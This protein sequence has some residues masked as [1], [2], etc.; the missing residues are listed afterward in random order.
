MEA[1]A[2][3]FH[4]PEKC[5]RFE[6]IKDTL[7][8][9]PMYLCPERALL[10]TDYFKHHDDPKEPMVIRKAKAFRH[11]LENKSVHIFPEELIV[12]NIGSR[13]KSAIIQPELA[14]VFVSQDLL[15]IDK[16][17]TTPLQSPWP[18]RIKLITKVLPY[19]LFRNMIVRAF[20]PNLYEFVRYS[21]EQ[22]NAT[23]YLVNE[24][25]G[26]GHF[27][28]NYPKMI[29]LGVNGYLASMEDK[30]GDLHIAARIACEGLLAYS[31]RLAHEAEQ[32]A[33][34][35]NDSNRAAE[36]R[37]I[38]RIC[39][40]V[41]REPAESFHEALQSLWLT[42]LG[43]CLEGINSAISFGR[44]DQYLYPY[45][46]NDLKQG[47]I[48]PEQVRELLLCFS[49]KTTEHVFLIS[50]RTSTHH[51]G[52]L[53]VQAAT[54]GGMDRDGKDAT[55]DLTYLF[56]DVMELSGL[57][58][59][60]Y[61]ARIHADSPREYINRASDVARK[62][63]GVPALFS[64]NT[65]IESLLYHGYPLEEARDYG[66][67]GC[68]EL[69]LP[70]K[71]F[72][73]T[74]AALFN[75]PVCI[76][77]ALNQGKPFKGYRR[78]G[79]PTPDPSSFTGMDQFLDAFQAQVD[80]MTARMIKDLQIIETG[81]RDYHPTPFSSM[82]V[83]GCIESGR[84]VTAGGALYNSSGIQGV[85]VA[86]TADCLAAIED[87][88]FRRKK[89]SLSQVIEAIKCNF[90]DAPMLRAE[91]VNAPK[92]GNDE[93]LPDDYAALVVK[94]FHAALARHSNT[95]GGPYVPGFYSST[96]HVAF[97]EHT[98]ALPNGRLAAM[99]FAASLGSV[100][101]MDRCGPTALLNSVA[102]ID[103][104]LSPNGYA[105]NLRFDPHTLSG[106]RGV[107]VLSALAQ[108]YFESGGMEMQL[109]VVDPATLD[110]ARKNPGKYPGLVLRVAGYC[111]YFDDLA[112]SVKLEIINRT[113]LEV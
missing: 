9:S 102:H 72:F 23:Y 13:R 65:A 98:G 76:E 30:T 83:D 79:A 88:V 94:L 84:D 49:A 48:T 62:G 110:D 34:L 53:I 35:E 37:N 15:W 82:L 73:S 33:A 51:S 12:G 71:S 42:H 75:L 57:R 104:R 24:V 26:I 89:Y 93:A 27:I 20:M 54:I 10:I 100:N 74:D 21:Y 80:H 61:H 19:W 58:D 11:L 113:R 45:Y 1:H 50:E 25:A 2:M 78:I 97:G 107:K 56:L 59:P 7:L 29:K 8:S 109:N 101:G 3:N 18:E 44:I 16:R 36:L 90:D 5:E 39:F 14:G 103:A 91:L 43:V 38:A 52:Y 67:V 70:G 96:S 32:L 77:L 64:D 81:N 60:N 63:K 31:G 68:V 41:P 69:S 4:E 66:I 17:K 86:D 47:R 55:N 105:L 85:G 111:A 46:L 92:F 28:P 106:E 22:L 40:R 95:R 112:D 99:T 6:K 87:V 108:G